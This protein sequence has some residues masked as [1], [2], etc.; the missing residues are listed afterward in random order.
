VETGSPNKGGEEKRREETK[1]TAWGKSKIKTGSL[2]RSSTGRKRR[3]QANKGEGGG[4]GKLGKLRGRRGS[5][6]L[7]SRVA[8]LSKKRKAFERG[9]L[10]LSTGEKKRKEE[11]DPQVEKTKKK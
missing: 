3:F 2:A 5:G 9:N 10:E 7:T 4:R 11:K 1:K 8:E 6:R